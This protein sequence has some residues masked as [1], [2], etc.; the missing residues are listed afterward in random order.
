MTRMPGQEK[1]QLTM[2][3]HTLMRASGQ[4]YMKEL[5]PTTYTQ[6]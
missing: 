4:G 3:T 6:S 5:L 1:T 2:F